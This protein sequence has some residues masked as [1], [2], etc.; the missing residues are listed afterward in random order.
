[1]EALLISEKFIKETTNVSDNLSGKYLKPAIREAQDLRLKRVIGAELMAKLQALVE[2]DEIEKPE[3]EKYR[4][5][6][7]EVRYPLAYYTIVELIDKVAFKLVNLGVVQNTD[8]NTQAANMEDRIKV[9][10]LYQSK[11]DAYTF[12]LQNYL[13]AHRSEFPE[14]T[15]CDC[16]KIKSNL[17][18]AATC[19][20]FLGG[21]RGKRIKGGC[22]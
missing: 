6:L 17:R 19:G 2:S 3:N 1:M 8:D 16:H 10:I 13:L 14:L 11:A 12:E 18:S 15:D 20:F 9:K 22:L 5:L 4:A 7:R 21:A